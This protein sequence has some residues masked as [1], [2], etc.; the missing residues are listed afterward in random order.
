[1]NDCGGGRTEHARESAESSSEESDTAGL[2]VADLLLSASVVVVVV[3]VDCLLL[4]QA[5]SSSCSLVKYRV[6]SRVNCH[7]KERLVSNRLDTK[8]TRYV[9]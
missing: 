8:S 5:A 6:I 9:Q 3:V 7:M 2:G 1:M 4:G